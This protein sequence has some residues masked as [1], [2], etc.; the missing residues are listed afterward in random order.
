MP[1][2][3]SLSKTVKTVRRR[4]APELLGGLKQLNDKEDV[5][6]MEIARLTECA[7]FFP[8]REGE[9]GENGGEHEDEK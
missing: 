2:R 3:E 8:L 5:F 4:R 1:G 6:I 7:F 9:K